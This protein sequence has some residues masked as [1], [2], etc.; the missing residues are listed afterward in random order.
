MKDENYP[1]GQSYGPFIDRGIEFLIK[2]SML[3][4]ERLISSAPE[5]LP[6]IPD[7]LLYHILGSTC[8]E[9]VRQKGLTV[10][11][12]HSDFDWQATNEK[13]ISPC[14]Y[15][16]SHHSKKP[17]FPLPIIDIIAPLSYAYV[18]HGRAANGMGKD[19]IYRGNFGKMLRGAGSYEVN[20][21]H[22]DVST[23]VHSLD[24]LKAG[25]TIAIAPE[26]GSIEGH[27]IPKLK[28]SLGIIAMVGDVEIINVATV[29]EPVVKNRRFSLEIIPRTVLVF[30][31]PYKHEWTDR[32][33]YSTEELM[34]MVASE[35]LRG[36]PLS[37]I[38]HSQ[39]LAEH[40]RQDLQSLF[41]EG[42]DEF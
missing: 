30:G 32:D 6:A 3:D 21:E 23:M 20:R 39:V 15:G 16:F 22:P 26:G 19:S 28:R 37:L 17:P 35:G 27:K 4:R 29:T 14:V 24:I 2:R 42:L 18:S 36:L 7:P 1:A 9:L 12:R 33:K 25:G 13:K 41:D 40:Q 8:L 38:K 31:E 5:S 10:Y 11:E 34:A